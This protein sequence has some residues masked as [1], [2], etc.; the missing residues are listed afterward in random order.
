MREELLSSC[1]AE[2][3]VDSDKP[4]AVHRLVH[5]LKHKA[6]EVCVKIVFPD[7][8][9]CRVPFTAPSVE[10]QCLSRGRW[11]RRHFEALVRLEERAN[12]GMELEAVFSFLQDAERQGLVADTCGSLG[13]ENRLGQLAVDERHRGKDGEAGLHRGVKATVELF[14]EELVERLGAIGV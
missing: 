11:Q 6:C 5:S 3:L 12:E 9:E 7:K 2:P 14:G 8:L 13:A 4:A 10:R 1:I